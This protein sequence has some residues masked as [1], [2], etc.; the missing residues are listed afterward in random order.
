MALLQV[1]TSWE[2]VFLPPSQQETSGGVESPA[3]D[4]EK[5]G[6]AAWERSEVV[7]HVMRLL[8]LKLFKHR[9]A[10]LGS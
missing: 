4:E 2:N 6:S 9:Q 10:L 5:V 1:L 7:R 3:N 8:A